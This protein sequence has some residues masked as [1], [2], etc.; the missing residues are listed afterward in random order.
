M[1]PLSILRFAYP[2]LVAGVSCTTA[3]TATL[4]SGP[5]VGIQ[6]TLPGAISPVN[7]FL[8]I[9]YA[10]TPERFGVPKPPKPWKKPLN[11]SEFGPSCTQF[12]PIV[13]GK[14]LAK[15]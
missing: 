3:P 8:G 6:T 11:T 5:I 13:P 7:K 4:D 15:V 14:Q 2:G 1:K 10:A 12:V 9:P